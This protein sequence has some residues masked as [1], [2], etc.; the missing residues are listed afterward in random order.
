MTMRILVTGICGFVGSTLARGL[1]EGWP[2]WEIVGLDNFVRAG[3]ETNRRTLRQLGVKLFHGDVRNPERPRSP[4]PVRLD[5]R[6]GRQPERARRRGRQ[7]QQPPVDR[8]QPRRHDQHA[9]TAEELALRLH[10]AQHQ[11]GLFDSRAGCHSGGSAGR[12]VCSRALARR[13]PGFSAQGVTE[14][15]STE[16]PLSLYGTFQAR[17]GATGLRVCGE[18]RSARVCAPLRG[19]GRRGAVRQD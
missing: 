16:P 4:A 14:D 1:R 10:H 11:P 13:L 8:A 17:L 7:D 3:S 6:G 18:L 9:G 5:H 15:F 12:P 19:A 2:D